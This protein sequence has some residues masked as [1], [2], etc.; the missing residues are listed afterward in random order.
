VLDQGRV[1][2]CGS[3]EELLRSSQLYRRIFAR[4]DHAAPHAPAAEELKAA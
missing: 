2:A 4:Y 3:H 1:A